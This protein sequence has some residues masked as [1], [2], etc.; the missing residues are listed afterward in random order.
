MATQGTQAI[1]RAADLV[2]RV[3]Q[4]PDPVSTPELAQATGLAR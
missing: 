2:V 1:D 3:V 4:S